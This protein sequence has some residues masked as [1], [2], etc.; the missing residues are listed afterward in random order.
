M[1]EAAAA[2]KAEDPIKVL[3][4]Q[5]YISLAA[6]SYAGS[7][8]TKG[9]PEPKALGKLSFQLASAFYAA[10]S[11]INAEAIA[12]EKSRNTFTAA[13]LDLGSIKHAPKPA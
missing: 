13:D 3:A 6:Q 4:R 12:V 9:K 11:E 5:I 1:S 8:E 10:D 7:A 2:P